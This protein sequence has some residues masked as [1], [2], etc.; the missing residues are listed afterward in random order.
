MPKYITPDTQVGDVFHIWD[1][2]EYEQHQRGRNWYIL[3]A[4]AGAFF[5]GYAL[6]NSNPLFALVVVLSGVIIFLQ[7]K[8]IPPSHQFAIAETGIVIGNKIY[9]YSEFE[10]FYIIYQ[11]PAVKALFIETKD[12]TRP[13][14]RIPLEDGMDP[15]DLRHTLRA[16]LPENIEK[17]E[18]PMMDSWVRKMK[19]H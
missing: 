8:Q 7:A 19:I 12:V 10:E 15:L 17:E 6:W 18:E 16:Y 2:Q 1:V 5:I 11:P 14:M 4:L 3:I 9:S 13:K